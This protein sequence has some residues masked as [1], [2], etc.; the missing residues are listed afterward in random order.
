[1]TRREGEHT[2]GTGLADDLQVRLNDNIV[3]GRS[4]LP[5]LPDR[6]SDGA[7]KSEWVAYAIGLGLNEDTSH[8]WT[9]AQLMEWVGP[10]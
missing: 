10:A 6:P 1:V 2:D 7:N 8:S 5:P 3:Q 4:D 9:K